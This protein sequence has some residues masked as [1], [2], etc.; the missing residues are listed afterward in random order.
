MDSD[1]DNE[2]PQN[3]SGNSSN[4]QPTVPVLFLH[5]RPAASAQGPAAPNKSVDED[6][7]FCDAYGHSFSVVTS[8]SRCASMAASPTIEGVKTVNKAGETTQVTASE[9]FS[10]GHLQDH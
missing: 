9:T 5:Q 1:E 2:E 8:F 6:S 3:E 7:G 10:S 4:S